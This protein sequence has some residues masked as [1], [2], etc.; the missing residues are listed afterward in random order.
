MHY[1]NGDVHISRSFV[2]HTAESM[3][4]QDPSLEMFYL[5]RCPPD[6]CSDIPNVKEVSENIEHDV[7][8][9]EIW[10]GKDIHDP[11]EI[12]RLKVTG[13]PATA[14]TFYEPQVH[15]EQA[16]DVIVINTWV[17]QVVNGWVAE[18]DK[19]RACCDLHAHTQLWNST[20]RVLG[21]MGFNI[22]SPSVEETIPRINYSH[23]EIG[24]IDNHFKE[25]KDQYRKKVF[26]ANGDVNSGQGSNTDLN[27]TIAIV[28]KHHPD[29]A[30]YMTNNT[31]V[32]LPNVYMTK[33]I[34]QKKEG[35]SDLN[36]NSYLSTFCDLI[37]SRSSGP[38]TFAECYDNYMDESKTILASNNFPEASRHWWC[39]GRC[40][41][42]GLSSSNPKKLQTTIQR[43]LQTI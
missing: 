17:G 37:V 11:E 26:W 3:L 36:E 28:A 22:P 29:I 14:Q 41:Y 8:K 34:I 38:G 6:C 25:T 20:W 13:L 35:F 24:N 30:F 12:E 40:K 18:P 21:E 32:N 31:S 33:N 42:E 39:G 15:V 1:N 7:F 23:Y 43:I 2:K 19:N 16:G 5:H 4:K 10:M 9:K 27:E